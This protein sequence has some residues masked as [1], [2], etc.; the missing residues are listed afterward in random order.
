MW[1]RVSR[2]KRWS[3]LVHHWS[4]VC[5]TS[6]KISSVFPD[7]I[8]NPEVILQW[9]SWGTWS[10]RRWVGGHVRSGLHGARDGQALT[11]VLIQLFSQCCLKAC[12]IKKASNDDGGRD[13]VENRKHTYADHQALQLLGLGSVVLHDGADTKQGHEA[14]EQE[15]GAN[16]EV[17]EERGQDE[18]PQGI[19]IV[20]DPQADAT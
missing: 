14:S 13:G 12:S 2:F 16:E 1:T 19:Q 15:R 6:S 7:Q 5:R 3:P 10:W 17:D 20:Q 18:A 4:N 9:E 11:V 8:Q